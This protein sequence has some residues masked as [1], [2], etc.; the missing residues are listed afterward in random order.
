[1]WRSGCHR[2]CACEEK[3][4]KRTAK[5][6]HT[7]AQII[8]ALR[9]LGCGRRAGDVARELGV[10]K[11]RLSAWKTKYMREAEEAERLRDENTRVRKLVAGLKLEEEMHSVI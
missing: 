1:M 9:Q 7:E 8:G 10:S 3:C 11:N 6:R 4:R 5:N 2:E